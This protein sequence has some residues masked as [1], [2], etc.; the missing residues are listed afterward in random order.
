MI[1][2]VYRHKLLC[3]NLHLDILDPAVTFR[4]EISIIK[5]RQKMKVIRFKTAISSHINVFHYD[6]PLIYYS[7]NNL[8]LTVTTFSYRGTMRNVK[9][10]Y[11]HSLPI[12][13]E[14]PKPAFIPIGEIFYLGICQKYESMHL[15]GINV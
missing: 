6:T 14:R 4:M 5:A 7:N 8:A 15:P 9:S 13:E 3:V 2:V 1:T 11:V 10:D 12:F